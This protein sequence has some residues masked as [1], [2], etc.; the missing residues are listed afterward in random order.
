MA[1][2]CRLSICNLPYVAN[3][4]HENMEGKLYYFYPQGLPKGEIR[5]LIPVHGQ[6]KV[7]TMVFAKGGYHSELI[8]LE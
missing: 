1:V 7:I 2:V 4:Y 6:N 8:E 3:K 5:K